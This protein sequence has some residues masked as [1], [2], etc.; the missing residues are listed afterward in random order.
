[1]EKVKVK[2]AA[3]IN[4]KLVKLELEDGRVGSS[5]SVEFLDLIGKEVEVEVKPANVY[6]GVQQYYFNIAKDKKAF[7]KKDYTVEKKI[8]ALTAASKYENAPPSK[9]LEAAE[10]YLAWLNK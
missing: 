8:A 1:M 9:I 10:I 4:E 6:Q 7:P 5:F 3:K 2:S